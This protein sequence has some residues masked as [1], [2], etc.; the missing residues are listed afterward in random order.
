MAVGAA[1]TVGKEAAE[2]GSR[3]LGNIAQGADLKETVKTEGKEG[4]K[5]VLEKATSKL[6]KGSGIRRRRAIKRR[7][8]SL[9]ARASG[10]NPKNEI[11]LKPD[12]DLVGKVAPVVTAIKKRA[13][14]DTLGLY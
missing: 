3:I 8:R 1:K 7:G 2:A 9:T 11:I 4:V 6:Q 14:S 10:K 5:R 12:P 13:K